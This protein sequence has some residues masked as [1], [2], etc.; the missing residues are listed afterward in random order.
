MPASDKID[1]LDKIIEYGYYGGAN[2][3]T[4]LNVNEMSALR[5]I[6]VFACVQIL[7]RGLATPPLKLFERLKPGRRE[8]EELNLYYLLHDQPNPEM[9]S[10]KWRETKQGH[11]STWG[12]AYSEI[13]WDMSSGTVK[14]LWPLR[15]DRMQVTREKGKLWYVYTLPNGERVGLPAYR[16]FHVKGFGFNGLTGYSPIGLAREAI[17]LDMAAER[18]GGKFFGNDARPGGVIKHPLKLT[19][20]AETRL[21]KSWT[22]MHQGLDNAHRIAILDEGMEWEAIGL[23]NKDIQFIE[24]RKF[25]KGEIATLYNIPC[26]W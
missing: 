22:K 17:G 9:S 23:P 10:Y 3:A 21:R 25:Q 14:A 12:N 1:A 6:G 26:T 19:E 4:G 24:N 5:S 11:L 8:A 18:Y 7:S 20:E 15:P 2:T 16:V 13:E